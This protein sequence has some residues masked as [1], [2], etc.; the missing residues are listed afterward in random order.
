MSRCSRA[1]AVAIMATTAACTLDP[2]ADSA[3]PV[4]T[5]VQALNS[6]CQSWGCGAN[7]PVV[8][9][10]FLFHD[11]STFANGMMGPTTLPN[12]AGIGIVA[13]GSHAQIE[14]RGVSYDLTVE[15]GRF[16]GR[17]PW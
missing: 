15:D 17:N 13:A 12:E 1:A 2:A 10:R 9:T 7:S 5:Q 11:A 3:I 16:V 6:Q 4:D 14:Q 8:D